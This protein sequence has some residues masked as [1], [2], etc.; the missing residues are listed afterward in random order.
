MTAIEG[1]GAAALLPSEASVWI[2][3]VDRSEWSWELRAR[4]ELD[5]RRM[6]KAVERRRSEAQDKDALEGWWRS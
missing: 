6:A 5:E 4:V 2:S 3:Y 1:G